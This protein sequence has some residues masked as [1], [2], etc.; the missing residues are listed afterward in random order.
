MKRYHL[1]AAILLASALAASAAFA[2]AAA[3]PAPTIAV[4]SFVTTYVEP[5][6]GA[7]LATFGSLALGYV[8]RHFKIAG[9]DTLRA[10]AD[11]AMRNG[12]AFGLSKLTPRRSRAPSTSP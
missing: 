7:T 11:T 8:A 2:D 10:A 9:D 1:G 3:T 5:L 4:G 12:I 6:V